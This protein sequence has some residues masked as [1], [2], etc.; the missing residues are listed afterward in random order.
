MQFRF[1]HFYKPERIL[2]FVPADQNRKEEFFR[3]KYPKELVPYTG[4][5]G[6]YDYPGL[7]V[8]NTSEYKGSVLGIEFRPDDERINYP[9]GLESIRLLGIYVV[10]ATVFEADSLSDKVID[11]VVDT[12]FN[13]DSG[14]KKP[15]NAEIVKNPSVMQV[16]YSSDKIRVYFECLD[17]GKVE[18][19][20]QNE[21]SQVTKEELYNIAFF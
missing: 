20:R 2:F 11:E 16:F 14:Y 6:T 10:E 19:V 5:F 21:L 18:M 13:M 9:K 3:S 7:F 1:N 8:L 15:M 17:S 12:V 4:A